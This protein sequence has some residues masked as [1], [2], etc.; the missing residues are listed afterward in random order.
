M[1]LADWI[2]YKDLLD[3]NDLD[4]VRKIGMIIKLATVLNVSKNKV[5]QDVNCD[6]LGDSV[7]L[8]T[9]VD[10]DAQFEILLANKLAPAFKKVFKKNLQVI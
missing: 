4:A 10:G 2:K 8:K 3:E 5:V 6:I 9:I 1:N 7:I